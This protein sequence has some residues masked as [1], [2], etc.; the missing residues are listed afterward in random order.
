MNTGKLVSYFSQ[1]MKESGA[2]IDYVYPKDLE[3]GDCRGCFTCWTNTPGKCVQED[4]MT[5][6]L[7]KIA[8]ADIIV[9]ATP[10]Y[11][12]GMTGSLKTLFD[13]SIPLLHG[14]FEIRNNHCRH[15]LRSHVKKG[16]IVLISVAGFTELDNFTPL[17]MHVKAISKNLNRDYSGAIL[18]PVAW[19][20]NGAKEQGIDIDEI[21]EAVQEAGQQ[22]ITD[23]S[24]KKETLAKISSEIVPRNIVVQLMTDFHGEK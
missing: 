12:D 20:M 3:I 4:D 19:I 13:R 2:T 17:I 8:D 22:L 5:T 16:K 6:V 1:G 24:M 9:L 7:E 21:Y 15:P 23:G 18:R 14:R 10:V 11:V